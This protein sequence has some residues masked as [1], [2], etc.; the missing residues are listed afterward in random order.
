MTKPALFPLTLVLGLM[1]AGAA[2]ADPCEARVNN[3]K[4]GSKIN[5]AVRYVG[6]GDSLCVWAHL[7]I[8]RLGWR[9]GSLTSTRPN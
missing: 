2:L 6:D 7:A 4:A 5:G 3:Y 1:S 8:P 9:S